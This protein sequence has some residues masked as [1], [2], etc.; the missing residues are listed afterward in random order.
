MSAMPDRTDQPSPSL[1]R[2]R[3]VREWLSAPNDGPVTLLLLGIKDLK[4]I[5]D[6]LGR[7][8]GD[9]SSAASGS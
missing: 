2:A 9:A 7:A 5:N 6:R 8:T 4:Q 3:D 1:R